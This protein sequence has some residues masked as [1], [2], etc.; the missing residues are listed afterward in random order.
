MVSLFFFS[1]ISP[2]WGWVSRTVRPRLGRTSWRAHSCRKR[3][4]RTDRSPTSSTSRGSST[5][6]PSSDRRTA[7]ASSV[8]SSQSR[9]KV[10]AAGSRRT[11]VSRFTPTFRLGVMACPSALIASTSVYLFC[12]YAG[13]S[14]QLSTSSRMLGGTGSGFGRR[15]RFGTARSWARPTR[16]AVASGSSRSTSANASSTCSDGLRSRPCSSRR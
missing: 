13:L 3:S 10:G 9:W 16:Y 15:R 14:V 2:T 11:L 5:S 4:L 1:S 8:R 6:D 7:T 12:T